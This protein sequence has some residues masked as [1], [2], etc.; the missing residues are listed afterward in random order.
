[1]IDGLDPE[2]YIM[3]R[4]YRDA[5]KYTNGTHV[6]VMKTCFFVLHLQKI[7]VHYIPS[8]KIQIII[9]FFLQDLGRLNRDITKVILV[10]CDS[11]TSMMQP[12][13]SLILKKWDGDREDIDLLE[14]IPFFHSKLIRYTLAIGIYFSQKCG[15]LKKANFF[16]SESFCP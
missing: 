2:G 7:N 6:K 4:L 15:I 8:K 10:D 11:R 1:M 9:D 12:R 3:Y 14:L 16:T 13:N 5:T